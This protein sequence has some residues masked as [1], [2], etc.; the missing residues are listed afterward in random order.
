M[1]RPNDSGF[2][3]ALTRFPILRLA[4]GLTLV[5]VLVVIVVSQQDRGS[6]QGEAQATVPGI[7]MAASQA[8]ESVAASTPAGR[9]TRDVVASTPAPTTMPE[10]QAKPDELA[11]PPDDEFISY[12][13]PGEGI[14]ANELGRIPIL[15]Y[16]AFVFNEANTDDW[17]ITFDQFRK[18]LDWLVANDF[19]MVG[20]S[21]IISRDFDVPAGKKPVV[22]TFDDA[23]G[24]QFRMQAADDGGVELNPDTAVGILE[25]YKKK[26]PAFGGPALLAVV[27]ANC[28]DFP[29]DDPSTCEQRLEWLV[30]HGYEVGNHTMTHQDLTDVSIDEFKDQVFGTARWFNERIGGPN[31]L[32]DVLVLPFGAYPAQDNFRAL[33]F[34]GFWL[35]GEY[36]V[37]SLV[38]EV[39]GGPTRSPFHIEWK[40]NIWRYNTEPSVFWDWADVIESG[41]VELFVSDGDASV[42]TVPEGWETSLDQDLILEDGRR[43]VIE[44]TSASPD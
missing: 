7:A 38:V 44:S 41:E 10:L 21:S 16:H 3:R 28:F 43:I 18:Q 20:M 25:E 34:D 42:V 22:L 9:P 26:Y 27:P 17:T 30:D 31:N 19:V 13:A 35:D 32:S 5:I 37:P 23:S 2:L 1:L 6:S 24:G 29:D 15:M 11:M 4:G 40:T 36:F 33:L 39:G 8:P 12:L 14:G